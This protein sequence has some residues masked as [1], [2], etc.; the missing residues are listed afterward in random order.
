M[1]QCKKCDRLFETIIALLDENIKYFSDREKYRDRPIENPWPED[2]RRAYAENRIN[3]FKIRKDF[4]TNFY[5]EKS[6]GQI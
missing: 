6:N 1:S 5:K 2:R 4:I 3:G